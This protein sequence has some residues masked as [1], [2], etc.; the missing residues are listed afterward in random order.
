MFSMAIVFSGTVV[1][2]NLINMYNFND[3]WN[4]NF[5]IFVFTA[6]I[7]NLIS[8]NLILK[9]RKQPIFNEE[10]AR[11]P[12]WEKETIIKCLVGSILYGLGWGIGNISPSSLFINVQFGT[13]HLFIFFLLFFLFGQCLGYGIEKLIKHCIS[14]KIG[15]LLFTSKYK[16]NKKGYR[17]KPFQSNKAVK[18][19][20][21]RKATSFY[22][23]PIR[24]LFLKNML[25]MIMI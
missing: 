12:K 9:F 23:N 8:I 25:L 17:V 22:Q 15:L 13:P 21:M 3:K 18:K 20:K 7:L 16:Q 19:L 6:F 4:P 11:R 2:L 10:F 24:Y 5:L 14:K 1:R